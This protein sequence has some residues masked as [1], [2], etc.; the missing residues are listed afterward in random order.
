MS[1][2]PLG[3]GGG[4]ARRWTLPR[5]RPGAR[6]TTVAAGAA[7]LL[8][9]CGSPPPY[10]YVASADRSLVVKLPAG[11]ASV[12]PT[13]LGYAKPTASRWVAFYDGAGKADPSHFESKLPISPP[14]D[15]VV[16]MLTVKL[17]GSAVTEEVLRDALTPGSRHALVKFANQAQ[18]DD[19]AVTD[20]GSKEQVVDTPQATG[21][22]VTSL[23]S[24][25]VSDLAARSVTDKPVVPDV[26]VVV[27]KMAV[28]DRAGEHLHVIQIWCSVACFAKNQQVVDQ[29]MSS[30]TVKAQP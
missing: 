6:A 27:D 9:A 12:D 22:R 28:A 23:F 8:A 13:A 2:D 17:G 21:L 30:F 7:A 5:R 3:R 26:T 25:D 24:F 20:F 29:I 10:Q 19:T 1:T 14:D 16:Q 18:L 4:W 15:P 11:W